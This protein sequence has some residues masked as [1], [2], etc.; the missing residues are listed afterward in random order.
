MARRLKPWTLFGILWTSLLLTC[1]LGAT[2]QTCTST[3]SIK[4]HEEECAC[5]GQLFQTYGCPGTGGVACDPDQS[6]PEC[7]TN[8]QT[9]CHIAKASNQFCSS[10]RRTGVTTALGAMPASTFAPRADRNILAGAP[11][12]ATGTSS[13]LQSP[14]RSLSPSERCFDNSMLK[15]WLATKLRNQKTSSVS[16]LAVRRS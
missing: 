10:D 8:G 2:G 15:A 9:E 5:T 14:T 4:M 11:I 7:G 3:G 6:D 1:P 16:Q 13:E 12:A